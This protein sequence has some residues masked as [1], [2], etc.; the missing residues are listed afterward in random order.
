MDLLAY[1]A[2]AIQEYPFDETFENDL[3]AAVVLARCY[4]QLTGAWVVTTHGLLGEARNLLRSAYESASLARTLAKDPK[5]ADQWIRDGK[6]FPDQRVRQW[7]SDVRRD[8]PEEILSYRNFYA[9]ASAWAHPTAESCMG[10]ISVEK[11]HF[12]LNPTITFNATACRETVAIIT[13]TALFACFAFRNAVV[14]EQAIPPAW[15]RDLHELAREISGDPM[16]HL[17]RDWEA[18]QEHY[19]AVMANLR[20][21]KYLKGQLRTHPRAYNNLKPEE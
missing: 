5:L 14:D 4:R 10:L 2:F 8:P 15:R 20:D 21:R 9:E 11:D 1:G 17:D 6:W 19:D 12:F 7:L 13:G 18:E 16:Y 3:S